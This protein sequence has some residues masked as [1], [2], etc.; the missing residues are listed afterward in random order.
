MRRASG[1]EAQGRGQQVTR[2]AQRVCKYASTFAMLIAHSVATADNS[3]ISG[4][5]LF[6]TYCTLCHG[7]SGQGDG[8]MAATLTPRPAN[9][10]VSGRDA[11]YKEQI[12]T[13]GGAA[14]G[15]SASMPSWASVLDHQQISAV[16]AY[17]DTLRSK[18]KQ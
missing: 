12:I 15:R 7:E 3:V 8:R 5:Q 10:T 4:A 17:L 16:V 2:L 1:Y 13:R 9:L 11:S 6:Q 14:L 18:S